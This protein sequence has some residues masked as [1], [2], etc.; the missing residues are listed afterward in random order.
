MSAN[1][2]YYDAIDRL[3]RN[4]PERLPPGT[5]INNDTVALEA[6]RKRGSI[7]KQRHPELCRDIDEAAQRQRTTFSA[8]QVSTIDNLKRPESADDLLKEQYRALERDYKTTLQKNVSLVY[9]VFMLRKKVALLERD[10]KVVS[11]TKR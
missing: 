8:V 11:L 7:K 2:D 4:E 3:E 1:D 10:K 6:G 9:E 5:L